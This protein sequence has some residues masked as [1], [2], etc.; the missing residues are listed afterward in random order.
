[1]TVPGARVVRITVEHPAVCLSCEEEVRFGQP[2]NWVK[3][4]GI[5]HADCP[6]PRNLA[7]YVRERDARLKGGGGT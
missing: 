3:G 4:V 5:W 6:E 7:T 1:M 2:A